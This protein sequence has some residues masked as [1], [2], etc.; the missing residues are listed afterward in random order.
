MKAD[1]I[2]EEVW[3]AKDELAR[4]FDYDLHRMAEHFRSKEEGFP[5]KGK[6]VP[7]H[8]KHRR[9]SLTRH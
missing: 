7:V 2:L 9:K 3:K 6:V 4:R 8:K 1:R 5:P